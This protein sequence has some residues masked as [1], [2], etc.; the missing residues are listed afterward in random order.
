MRRGYP[1]YVALQG[2][3]IAPRGT[4]RVGSS[5][6]RSGGVNRRT[7]DAIRG[8]KRAETWDIILS[9]CIPVEESSCTWPWC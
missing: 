4:M 2:W 5:V 7:G 3:R 9:G 1:A 6:A 8:A